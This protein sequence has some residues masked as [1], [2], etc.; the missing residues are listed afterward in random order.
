M[1]ITIHQPDFMPWAGFFERWH[2]SDLYLILDDVQYLK[3]G[4]HNRDRIRGPNG[5]HWLTVPVKSKGLYSQKINE[6]LID[7]GNNWIYKHLKSIEK[8]YQKCLNFESIYFEIEKIYNLKFEKLI[9]LNVELLKLFSQKLKINTPVKRSSKFKVTKTKSERLVELI[10]KNYGSTYLTGEGSKAYLDMQYFKENEIN[11]IW[12]K[13][14]VSEYKKL[15]KNFEENLSILDFL[16][17][18]DLDIDLF[19]NSNFN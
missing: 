17:I 19:I 4:W 2:A 11:V 13:F 15:Y 7:Y 6:V 3:R 9:D 5:I 14:K 8:A 16:M 18:N 10:I 1:I 12:Q